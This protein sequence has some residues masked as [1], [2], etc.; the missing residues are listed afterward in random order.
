MHLKYL[1]TGTG[2]CG[3][4]FCARS[5]TELGIPC[6]H[7]AIF[8]WR[9]LE[10]AI[11]KIN[12]E[13]QPELSHAS[14]RELIGEERWISD[15]N[16]L[17][18]ES[19]YMVAPY[20]SS[21]VI[22]GIPVIHVVRDPVKVVNSF[23]NYIDYFKYEKPTNLYEEFIYEQLPELRSDMHRFDRSALYVVKWNEMI[24]KSKPDFF[25]RVEDSPEKLFDFLGV[26]GSLFHNK[27]INSFKKDINEPFSVHKIQN[28]RLRKEFIDMGRR[29]G[30]KMVSELMM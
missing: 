9:G 3:T 5:L 19:S 27:E 4:V 7:E 6:G 24:E 11:K 10:L 26:K 29:Y 8:D 21:E 20:L 30:Y 13:I 15:L 1:I 16:A 17:E 25:Y 12:G 2:R 18:A 23:S 14:T 28:N 22:R